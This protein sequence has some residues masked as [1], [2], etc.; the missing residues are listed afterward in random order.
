MSGSD[1]P[2]VAVAFAFHSGHGHTAVL[3]EA[4]ARGAVDAGAEVTSVAVDAI[5]EEHWASCPL[6]ATTLPMPRPAASAGT[7]G[8]FVGAGA[9]TPVDTGPEAVHNSDVAH[10][11]GPWRTR[12]TSGRVLPR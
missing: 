6:P 9:R 11:R 12:R 8:Y 5:T 1:R 7:P 3:A 10:R 4:V 2:T